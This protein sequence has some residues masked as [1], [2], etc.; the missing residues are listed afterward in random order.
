[1]A[2]WARPAPWRT[3]WWRRGLRRRGGWSRG[4]T[5]GTCCDG[6]SCP[7]CPPWVKIKIKI[8]IKVNREVLIKKMKI[9]EG[10][11]WRISLIEMTD[12]NGFKGWNVVSCIWKWKCHRS[13]ENWPEESAPE[14]AAGHG[15][16]VVGGERGGDEGRHGAGKGKEWAS[17][18]CLTIQTVPQ[19]KV[20][21]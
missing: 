15:Q 11:L 17:F 4:W 6:R 19:S 21:L 10:D 1:M 12:Y 14:V 13:E 5:C 20:S 2:P 8:K 16:E 9:F 18:A 3:A 7:I